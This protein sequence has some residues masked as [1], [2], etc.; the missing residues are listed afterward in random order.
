MV[1]SVHRHR[2]E[3]LHSGTARERWLL[4][5]RLS[6]ML[7]RRTEKAQARDWMLFD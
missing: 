6:G 5:A 3:A 7:L 4:E 1:E 2:F